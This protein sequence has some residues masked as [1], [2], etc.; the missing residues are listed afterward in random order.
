MEEKREGV[1]KRFREEGRKGRGERE[2]WMK[3][4][5]TKKGEKE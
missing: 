5:V 3:G 4:R 1:R 2:G